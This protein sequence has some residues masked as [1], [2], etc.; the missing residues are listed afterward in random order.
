MFAVAATVE[1]ET[2]HAAG[3]SKKLAKAR[4]ARDALRKLY[5][6]EFGISESKHYYFNG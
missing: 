2:F 6:L 1:G 5:N 3:N 4:A